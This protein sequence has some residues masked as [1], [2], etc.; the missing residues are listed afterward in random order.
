MFLLALPWRFAAALVMM[1]AGKQGR[2]QHV[3]KSNAKT[4]CNS[5]GYCFS[6]MQS[7]EVAIAAACRASLF[8]PA[9]SQRDELCNR[10][11]DTVHCID[12]LCGDDESKFSKAN[13]PPKVS[14]AITF[15]VSALRLRF[16][17][18]FANL[19]PL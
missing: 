14:S 8:M 19:T 11:I 3:L 5:V 12:V 17:C 9:R 4:M 15:I 16:A 1:A 18:C 6:R 7:F 10:C 13:C 2:E